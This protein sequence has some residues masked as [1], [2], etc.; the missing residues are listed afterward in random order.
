[1]LSKAKWRKS[2]FQQKFIGLG[3]HLLRLSRSLLLDST[4]YWDTQRDRKQVICYWFPHFLLLPC[5]V[6]RTCHSN[7]QADGKADFF[8][9]FRSYLLACLTFISLT[10]AEEKA[11]S[12]CK[13]HFTLIFKDPF[14]VSHPSCPWLFPSVVIRCRVS[15]V[16]G[17]RCGRKDFFSLSDRRLTLDTLFNTSLCSVSVAFHL[18]RSIGRICLLVQCQHVGWISKMYSGDEKYE[19]IFPTNLSCIVVFHFLIR[20]HHKLC[21]FKI[22]FSAVASSGW[23]RGGHYRGG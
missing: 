22:I 10:E 12:K 19:R 3:K 6:P 9:S 7:E 16:N 17:T 8:C 18:S 21:V 23:L 15:Y 20:N 5:K 14:F 4:R 2:N 11:G 13:Y 1:M